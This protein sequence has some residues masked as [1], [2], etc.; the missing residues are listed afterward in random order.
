MKHVGEDRP[1]TDQL[2]QQITAL[3]RLLLCLKLLRG[4]K[5]R[6]SAS[7]FSRAAPRRV[8]LQLP[9]EAHG[10]RSKT[11]NKHSTVQ[12]HAPSL[13]PRIQR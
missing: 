12:L 6:G 11:L 2:H 1:K 7:R 9:A 3:K 5:A 10:N 8:Q 13:S 4:Y